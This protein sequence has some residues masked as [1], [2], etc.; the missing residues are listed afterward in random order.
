MLLQETSII[1]YYYVDLLHY[2]LSPSL[3]I[4][5]LVEACLP[6]LVLRLRKQLRLFL[7]LSL[8]NSSIV[9]AYAPSSVLHHHR[10]DVIVLQIVSHDVMRIRAPA[11]RNTCGLSVPRTRC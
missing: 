9:V 2:P 5:E 3:Q 1:E 4:A 11:A 8:P 10:I 6:I 7:V